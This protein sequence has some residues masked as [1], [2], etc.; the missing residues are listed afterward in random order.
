MH[1]SLAVSRIHSVLAGMVPRA[2]AIAGEMGDDSPD[3]Y[4]PRSGA[5]ARNGGWTEGFW[6][7][8]LWRLFGYTRAPRLARLARRYTLLLAD[9]K[10]AFT[11]HDLGFLYDHSCVLG[12][13]LTGDEGMMREALAAADRLAARFNPEGRFIRAAAAG[14]FC[15]REPERASA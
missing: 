6:T 1:E 10:R 9:R 13:A 4:D 11:D 2:L 5:W 14:G 15:H 7:G 8:I 12:H 3:F